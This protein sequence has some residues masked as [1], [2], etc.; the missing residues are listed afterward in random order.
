MSYNPTEWRNG[1]IVSEEGMNNIEDELVLLDSA[2]ESGGMGWEDKTVIAQASISADAW[3]AFG[4]GYGAT[5]EL[6]TGFLPDADQRYV[7]SINGEETEVHWDDN[8]DAFRPSPS[9]FYP[10]IVYDNGDVVL[11]IGQL[12]TA[13]EFEFSADDI[14]KIDSKFSNAIMVRDIDDTLD[15]TWQQIYDW[16]N[17]GRFVFIRAKDTSMTPPTLKLKMVT[18]MQKSQSQQYGT[19]YEIIC[20]ENFSGGNYSLMTY[21]VQDDPNGYP[22]TVVD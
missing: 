16:I 3:R 8:S 19:A 20:F 12:P 6:P 22:Q 21:S 9:Q 2:K 17:E 11:V 7:I 13:V 10:F 5:I 14:H 15:A 4:D 1:D 18:W